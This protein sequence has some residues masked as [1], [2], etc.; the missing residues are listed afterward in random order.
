[1][2]ARKTGQRKNGLINEVEEIFSDIGSGWNK[3]SKLSEE[4]G[5]T[6]GMVQCKISFWWQSLTRQECD[7]LPM[8][9]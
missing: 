2:A 8:L 6:G 4:H 9:K 7:Q 5:K 3:S 1:M